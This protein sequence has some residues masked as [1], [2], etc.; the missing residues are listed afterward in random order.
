[1]EYNREA[2]MPE[3]AVRFSEDEIAI[4]K[5]A[6]KTKLYRRDEP[7]ELRVGKWQVMLTAL[8]E[9]FG[10]PEVRLEIQDGD[11]IGAW[12]QPEANKIVAERYSL[13]SI[14]MAFSNALFFHKNQGINLEDENV[15]LNYSVD[16][17]AF[18]LSA[19]KQAAPIMF[20]TAKNAGRLC[21]TSVPY[22]DGGRIQPG[23]LLG[24]DSD[25]DV[26][27]EHDDVP[28]MRP[29]IDPENRPDRGNGRGED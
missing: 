27:D 11:R 8:S 25:D 3:D 24:G 16:A 20:E 6:L 29:D 26:D 1:M 18:G 23:D 19:F 13:V 10:V 4:V 21:G 9:K 15:Q 5:T 7:R 28:P 14:L 22:T 2:Q 17:L 12:F